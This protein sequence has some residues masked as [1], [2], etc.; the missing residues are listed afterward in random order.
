MAEAL[1]GLKRHKMNDAEYNETNELL[2]SD[3][4]KDSVLYTQ[5]TEVGTNEEDTDQDRDEMIPSDPD[6]PSELLK[7]YYC[8]CGPCHPNWLQW[9]AKKKIFTLLLSLFAFLEGA[10]VSGKD[11]VLFSDLPERK[12]FPQV[13]L[14]TRL[15]RMTS[16]FTIKV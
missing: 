14:G 2:R 13:S 11:I 16:I 7:V 3:T 4:S 1:P 8:G 6:V 9:F 12:S 10:V 15:A 5:N